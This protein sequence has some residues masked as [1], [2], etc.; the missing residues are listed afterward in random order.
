MFV[1]NLH[2]EGDAYGIYHGETHVFCLLMLWD[3]GGRL[4]S[5]DGGE[6]VGGWW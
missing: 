5:G 3:F 2:D 1:S 4:M 6:R